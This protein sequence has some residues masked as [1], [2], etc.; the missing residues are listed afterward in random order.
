MRNLQT[1]YNGFQRKLKCKVRGNEIESVNIF[2]CL[3]AVI[4]IETNINFYNKVLT[5]TIMTKYNTKLKSNV[6]GNA[7]AE[8]PSDIWYKKICW[9]FECN[10][11]MKEKLTLTFIRSLRN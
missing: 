11:S 10:I 5:E 2:Y 3:S 8:S 1:L 4:R 9:T 7:I 6:N